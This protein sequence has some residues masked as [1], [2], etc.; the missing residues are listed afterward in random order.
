MYTGKNKVNTNTDIVKMFSEVNITK[1][2]L[3]T[4]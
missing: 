2:W 1:Y 4:L 3:F